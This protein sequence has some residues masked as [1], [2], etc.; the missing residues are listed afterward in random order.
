MKWF[1]KCFKC[2]GKGYVVVPGER[3]T[4]EELRTDPA[5]ASVYAD[6]LVNGGWAARPVNKECPKCKGTGKR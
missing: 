4:R 1:T 3:Y 2:S 6:I 5:L